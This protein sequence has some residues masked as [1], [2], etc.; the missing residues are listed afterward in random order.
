MDILKV[1]SLRKR[2]SELRN[3]QL[4]IQ[5]SLEKLLLD[6]SSESSSTLSI[7]NGHHRTPFAKILTVIDNSPAQEAGLSVGDLV[8][9]FGPESKESLESAD[10]VEKKMQRLQACVLKKVSKEIKIY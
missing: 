9:R 4:R 3:D 8:I 1:C 7:Q 5:T 10:N 2:L 6:E